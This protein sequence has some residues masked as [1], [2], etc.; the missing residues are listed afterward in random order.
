MNT[1]NYVSLAICLAIITALSIILSLLS[2]DSI[3]AQI[4]DVIVNNT[5]TSE[6]TNF[7]N[8]ENQTQMTRMNS[9]LNMM[10][11]GMMTMY[12]YNNIAGS[13]KLDPI[14]NNSLSHIT[15][16]LGQATTIAEEEIGNNSR[17]I[18]A[19]LCDANGY[20][21]YMI[22][23]RSPNTDTTDVIVDPSNGKILLKN[24]NLFPQQKSMDNHMMMPGMH[25]INH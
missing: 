4:S 3:N 10:N 13:I 8:P 20:L 23:V 18:E 17:S 5:I 11:P 1:K 15:I 2:F 12:G 14:L 25:G 16:S 22:W 24:S 19:Y 7:S 6:G 21:V 9:C